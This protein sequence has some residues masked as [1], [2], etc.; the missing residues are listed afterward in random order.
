M[1][2]A[3]YFP[4]NR[5]CVERTSQNLIVLKEKGGNDRSPKRFRASNPS[6]KEALA[7]RLDGCVFKQET[8]C[9]SLLI[10]AEEAIAHFVEF[11]GEDIEKAVRQ[12]KASICKVDNSAYT[13]NTR[14]AKIEAHIICSRCPIKSTKLDNLKASFRRDLKNATLH[15]PANRPS[16]DITI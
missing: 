1:N 7:V 2:E 16:K 12:L 6:R 10:V 3:Q 15:S 5:N 14:F 11:K 4:G 13:S 8:S 9:D